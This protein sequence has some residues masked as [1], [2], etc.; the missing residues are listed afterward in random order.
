MEKKDF[1][2]LYNGRKA[3]CVSF[4]DT[5]MVQITYKPI[6]I[7]LK[8]EDDGTEHWLERDT[9]RETDLSKELGQLIR[10]QCLD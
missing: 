3:D 6:Y 2:I 10:E 9:C 8:K 1:S 7:E 5:F 4:G